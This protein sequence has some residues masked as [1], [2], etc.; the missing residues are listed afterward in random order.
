MDSLCLSKK[1]IGFCWLY[2]KNDRKR[3][4]IMLFSSIFR[5]RKRGVVYNR[6]NRGVMVQ[7]LFGISASKVLTRSMRLNRIR[8]IWF[9]S[10]WCDNANCSIRWISDFSAALTL[11]SSSLCIA[12]SFTVSTACWTYQ[13]FECFRLNHHFSSSTRKN[14][15]EA[16]PMIWI[17]C[18]GLSAVVWKRACIG[19][20]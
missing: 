2:E 5:I 10:S 19:G 13:A 12:C 16:T 8:R 11:D 6:L 14:T 20:A 18:I 9:I 3:G 7:K 15:D 4:K 17:H 1:F